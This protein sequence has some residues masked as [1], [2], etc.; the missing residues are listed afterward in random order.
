M[1]P[2]TSFLFQPDRVSINSRQSP[3]P[4]TSATLATYQTQNFSRFTNN[5]QTPL[6]NVK[7][8][9]LYRITASLPIPSIP[10]DQTVFFYYRI[11]TIGGGGADKYNPD[12]SKLTSAYI[13]IVRLLTTFVYSPSR[14]LPA[15]ADSYGFNGVFNDYPELAQILNRSA[16]ADPNAVDLAAYYTAGDVSFSYDETTKKII[17]QGNNYETVGGVPQYYYIPCGLNDPNLPTVQANLISILGNSIFQFQQGYTLNKRLGFLWDGTNTTEGPPDYGGAP[18]YTYPIPDYVSGLWIPRI[19]YFADSYADLLN[20][21]NIFL[22]CD[23]VGGSTRDTN[24]SDQLLAVV[25]VTSGQL[26]TLLYQS[27]QDCPLRKTA[28]SIYEISITMRT[29]TGA[30]FWIPTNGFVNAEFLVKY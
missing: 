18:N 14:Y 26:G 24:T 3:I 8:I 13:K 21:Q 10:N 22:Y 23:V 17:F 29:D 25:P 4:Y 27:S 1:K 15:I 5:L 9:E 28:N 16:S 30:D 12:Y 2:F 7:S 20:T 6:L 19:R 11:P